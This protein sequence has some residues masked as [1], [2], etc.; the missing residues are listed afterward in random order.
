V[1]RIDFEIGKQLLQLRGVVVVYH[2]FD[3]SS[4][5]EMG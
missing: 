4:V 2:K 3:L 5:T 1:K